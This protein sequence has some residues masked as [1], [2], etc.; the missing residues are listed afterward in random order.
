MATEEETVVGGLLHTSADIVLLVDADGRIHSASPT[1]ES[2]L[3][4]SNDLCA[5][6]DRGGPS[7]DNAEVIASLAADLAAHGD[8][9]RTVCLHDVDAQ[10]RWFDVAASRTQDPPD[11]VVVNARDVTDDHLAMRYLAQ[12]EEQW[13]LAFEQS[14]AGGALVDVDGALL[15]GNAALAA[16]LGFADVHVEHRTLQSLVADADRPVI[17]AAMSHVLAGL[18][19]TRSIEAHLTTADGRTIWG[20]LT[21]SVLRDEDGRALRL[22]VGLEDV[23]EQREAEMR[24]A[25]RALYDGLSGL[26]NRFMTRQWLASAIEEHG[27][28]GVGVLSCDLDRFKVVN[29]SL[30]DEVG[31]QLIA[32]AG[33]RIQDALR[34]RDLVGRVGGDEFVVVVEGVDDHEA[35]LSLARRVAASLDDPILLDGHLHTVTMSVG[36]VITRAPESADEALMRADMALSRAKRL[37]RARIEVFDATVDRVATREDLELE[38]RLRDSLES[39]ALRAYYQPIVRLTG[40]SIVGHETLI[41]WQH[42]DLGLLPPADFLALAEES[43]LIRPI[44]WWVLARACA[45]AADPS[46]SVGRGWVSV[47]ASPSQLS[48]PGVVDTIASILDE[49]GLPARR[50]HLEIT[51]TALIQA[52][53]GVVGD[54]RRLSEMGVRIALDDF[55]TGYSSLSLLRD[56]PVDMVKVDRSFVE[57]LTSDRSAAAIVRAVV[58]M[59]SDLGLPVVAEGVETEEQA[60]RLE[61]LGCSHGQGYLFGRPAPLPS[62]V[63]H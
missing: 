56:F 16:L 25:S 7:T 22:L 59:A 48:R 8:L 12:S 60:A 33:G 40:R 37:G 35:L 21:L 53:S 61:A 23:S 30:G 24:L 46:T 28:Q 44:G 1:L 3:G 58:S 18:E 10:P 2:I 4:I 52:S 45:D 11:A 62:P 39:D 49:T 34:D 42:E 31:D 43:G 29:D 47:N 55:G 41:R 20:R 19:D 57:P 15:H 27:G 36:A 54:L 51:E 63:V 26:P 38:E 17:E 5:P 50:L 14:P 32:E 13:R 6:A 9:R